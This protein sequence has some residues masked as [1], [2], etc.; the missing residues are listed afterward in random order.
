[1]MIIASA[2][3]QTPTAGQVAA[4]ELAGE[5]K[6][7]VMIEGRH[8]DAYTSLLDETARAAGEW[9]ERHLGTEAPAA[10]EDQSAR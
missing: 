8:Y 6:R 4:F 7:K 5:P 9:F 2:D 3:T 10:D 1:M